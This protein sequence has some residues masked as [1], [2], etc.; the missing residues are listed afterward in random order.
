MRAAAKSLH[1]VLRLA[2]EECGSL[3]TEDDKAE[4]AEGEVWMASPASERQEDPIT[5]ILLI[6]DVNVLV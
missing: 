1:T 3:V 4:W 5:S 2:P 6:L